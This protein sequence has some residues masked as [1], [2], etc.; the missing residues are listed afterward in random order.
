MEKS[1]KKRVRVTRKPKSCPNPLFESWLLELKEDAVNKQSKLQF[2]YSKALKSLQR[3][4]LV[5]QSG[6]ECKVLQHFGE[7]LCK[8]LDDK[9]QKHIAN[10]G[11]LGSELD[12]DDEGPPSKKNC[13]NPTPQKRRSKEY[14]PTH[15]S[16]PYAIL[17]ALYQHCGAN[18]Y[19]LKKDLQDAAQPYAD[20]SFTQQ[21][22][23]QGQYYTAWSSMSTLINKGLVQKKESELGGSTTNICSSSDMHAIVQAEV[24][25]PDSPKK[26]KKT[27]TSKTNKQKDPDIPKT[28]DDVQVYPAGSP[29]G[30]LTHEDVVQVEEDEFDEYSKQLAYAIELSKKTANMMKKD[31]APSKSNHQQ[32]IIPENNIEKVKVTSVLTKEKPSC[33]REEEIVLDEVENVVSSSYGKITL[34][35]GKYDIILCVDNAE[36]AGGSSAGSGRNQKE[37]AAKAF[38]N[39]GVPYDVRKLA[40]GDYMWVA[41]PK[42]ETGLTADHELALPFVIERKRIDDLVSSI[43]DGRFKEQKFRLKNSGLSRPIYL[44]EEFGNRQNHALPEASIL[45]AVANTLLIENFQ[46]HWT[47]SSQESVNYMVQM[48]K[49]LTK[50]YSGK[51]LISRGVQDAVGN[52]W[53]TRLIAFKEVYV[54]STKLKPLSVTQMFAKHLIQLH[55]LSPEKAEAI[56]KVYPTPY[57]FM[58]FLKEAGSSA[59][60]MLASLEYG[61]AKR[62]LG[63]AMC[64]TLCEFFSLFLIVIFMFVRMLTRVTFENRNG[65][66]YSLFDASITRFVIVV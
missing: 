18:G 9:L 52:D 29:V 11:K 32:N 12:S 30:L 22:V 33:S 61:K 28:Y 3:Y 19:L 45:Q 6:R 34:N 43:K 57:A 41:K 35:P 5:L 4:P 26:K 37:A 47:R 10:G 49:Q 16:G 66:S 38:E 55:G 2:V 7:G 27:G 31:D 46:I 48:T 15:R 51:T 23:L 24:A 58:K 44:V 50:F 63:I 53:Q 42:P 36:V 62:K 39:C 56:V 1:N 8:L 59:S 64:T 13:S 40:I 20:I 14:I 60:T 17:L 65:T 54:N 21:N 25:K